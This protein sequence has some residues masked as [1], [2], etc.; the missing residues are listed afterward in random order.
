LR[1]ES[2]RA[3]ER[4]RES[5][6]KNKERERVDDEVERGKREEPRRS[7][8]FARYRSTNKQTYILSR[9]F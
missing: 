9:M 4:E 2:E 7:A 8:G 5:E 3:S 1:R 6:H